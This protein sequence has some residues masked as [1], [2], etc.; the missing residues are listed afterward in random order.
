MLELG[1]QADFTLEPIAPDRR[2][3]LGQQD[4]DRHLAIV[5][6]V[7]SKVDDGHTTP[8]QFTT[9]L[10]P[11]LE[12]CLETLENIGFCHGGIMSPGGGKHQSDGLRRPGV[13]IG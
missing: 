3:Q 5:L 1:G 10:V 6:P 8:T 13:A 2:G 9:E 7:A 12:R 11:V 4:L